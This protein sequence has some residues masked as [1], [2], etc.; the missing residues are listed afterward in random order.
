MSTSTPLHPQDRTVP[1]FL[2]FCQLSR[3]G[4]FV[5]TKA[6]PPRLP[7][8]NYLSSLIETAAE[9]GF[10][11]LLTATNY[12]HENETWTASVAALART[13]GA[14]LLIAV[15]PGMYHP[16]MF[17]KMVSTASNLFPGRVRVNIVTGSSPES[18]TSMNELNWGPVCAPPRLRGGPPPHPG[19][20]ASWGRTQGRWPAERPPPA[21]AWSR[22]RSPWRTRP[23]FRRRRCRHRTR[24]R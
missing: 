18:G 2:W 17:A 10:S 24:Q 4:E 6:L 12:H 22:S 3:D 8:L 20:P 9:A 7:T 23:P 11:S 21:Q 14:G 16:A 5:G 15:R 13:Q 1:D 19:P